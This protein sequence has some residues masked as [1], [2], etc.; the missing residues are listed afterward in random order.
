VWMLC[1]KKTSIRT[2]MLV[3]LLLALMCIGVLQY[4]LSVIGNGF[5]DNNKQLYCFMLCHDL[6]LISLLS[7]G[8]KRLSDERRE[9]HVPQEESV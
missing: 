4:P 8:V 3:V 6:L 5:A 2:R 7:A 1:R 9:V